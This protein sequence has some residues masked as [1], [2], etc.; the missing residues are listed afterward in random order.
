MQRA[1]WTWEIS[2]RLPLR[3]DGE[4][5]SEKTS[6]YLGNRV[7][8]TG[9]RKGETVTERNQ[10]LLVCFYRVQRK[11]ECSMVLNVFEVKQI[12]IWKEITGFFNQEA[13][14]TFL[15]WL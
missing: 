3:D 9:F 6:E 5:A 11:R 15:T 8:R 13:T 7:D 2:W 1:A 14:V 12:K 10:K 4:G